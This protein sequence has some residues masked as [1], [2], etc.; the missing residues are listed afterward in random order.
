VPT[1]VFTPLEYGCIGLS[2][3]AALE[4]YGPENIEVYHSNFQALEHTLPN[5]N[6]NS[7]YVKLICVKPMNVS[8]LGRSPLWG[9]Q[10]WGHT[11]GKK[12]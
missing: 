3:E 4:K 11:N 8:P 2:E 12:I 9:Q 5:R 1:T 7:G 10:K 6:Q